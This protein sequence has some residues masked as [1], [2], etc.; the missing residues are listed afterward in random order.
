MQSLF[1]DSFAQKWTEWK[2][3]QVN[4]INRFP[5]HTDFFTYES[6]DLALKGNPSES[7]NYRSL[8]GLWKFKWV[9]NADQRPLDF[10]KPAFDE[11][12]WTTMPVPGIWEL[13]GFGDPEYVNIG[14]AWR[15]HFENNP[16]NPPVK[17][18]HVG[19][20]RRMVYVPAEWKGEQ[21]IAHFGSVTSNM[22]LYI[23]GKFVGYAE[24]SKMAAEFDITMFVKPGEE[25]LFAFQTF[26]WCDG[27][28]CEDQDFWRLSGVGR[29]CW[30]FTRNA[31]TQLQDIRIATDLVDDFKNGVLKVTDKV[32][33]KEKVHYELLDKRGKL[34]KEFDGAQEVKIEDVKPWTAET[35]YLYKLVA[36][37]GDSYTVQRVGFRNVRIEDVRF[38]VNGKAIYIKGVN[39]HEMSPDKGYYVTREEMIEDIK[40]MKQLNINAVRTCHY[41]DDPEWYNLCDEY[42]IYLCA[43]ANQESHGFYYDS[44]AISTTPLFHKQIMERNQHNVG[45]NYNHPSIIIW[46]LG[47]ET[48]NGKNFAD[49]KAWIHSQD[50]M[51]PVMFE[52]AIKTDNTDI[53]D[54]MYMGHVNC[55]QYNESNAP[56]DQ[57]PLIECE[58]AHAMGNSGG[59]FKEY[60]DVVRENGKFQGGFIWDFADQAL[61]GSCLDSEGREVRTLQY[62]GCYNDYDPSDNNFNCNGIVTADRQ[63]TPQAYEIQYQYQNIWSE[64]NPQTGE[65]K[66]KNEFFFKDLKNVRLSWEIA[67]DGKVVDK[68]NVLQLY[69]GPQQTTVINLPCSL[70]YSGKNAVLNLYYKLKSNEP[71]QKVGTTIAK[72]QFVL[73]DTPLSK[74]YETEMQAMADRLLNASVEVDPQTGFVTSY[75]LN[76]HE[77]LGEGGVIRPQLWRAVNDNDMG[78][79]LQK[80]LACWRDLQFKAESVEHSGNTWVVTYNLKAVK[81]KMIV[82]YTLHENG[83]LTVNEK[84]HTTSGAKVPEMLRFGMLAEL[85]Y[86]ADKSE[87]YGRGPV[88]NYNDRCS[89]YFVGHYTQSADEQF[90]KYVRPQETGNHTGIRW[91]KQ[92]NLKVI[93]NQQFQASAL[94]YSVSEMDEGA[95]KKQRHPEQLRKSKYTNLNIDSEMAG[96]GGID[97][98]SEWGAALP[99]YKVMYGD[100]EFEFTILS[101]SY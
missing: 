78:A 79:D 61:W 60:W 44:D 51:R 4:D 35:P 11:S 28:Y 3:M 29:D 27:S 39:R 10:F 32:L 50:S 56:E 19:S 21:I 13:N 80:R 74:Q 73:S 18:N 71:L 31:K 34:V 37:L 99:E 59:G 54:P 42:G 86:Y 88:E 81:S 76:G 90:W 7:K 6:R 20:Y 64:L 17:D 100:K 62:G 57:K 15:G 30:M 2:D 63:L 97:S 82:T 41:P 33:G 93:S 69:A 55:K 46:S 12:D 43:E 53:F 52:R 89:G 47:N 49:A 40:I 24:D 66:I 14:F 83:A 9:E 75:K 85:P 25:N 98:W 45:V 87:W 65:L 95:E 1:S 8:N 72:Q 67:V 91:W 22:Y 68:G 38:K 101:T 48:A 92:G 94:H 84:L 5:V 23:N 58:Y 16:P 70:D 26:R 96:V 77:Q 36:R